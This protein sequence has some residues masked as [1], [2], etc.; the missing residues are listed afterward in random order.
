ME[1]EKIVC[2]TINFNKGQVSVVDPGCDYENIVKLVPGEY[3]CIGIFYKSDTRMG[4]QPLIESMIVRNDP[5]VIER[6]MKPFQWEPLGTV[7]VDCGV[8]GYFDEKPAF[9]E[10]A[11]KAFVKRT[12]ANSDE[13]MFVDSDKYRGFWTTTGGDGSYEVEGITNEDGVCEAVSICFCT[14]W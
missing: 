7:D 13:Y 5:D 3:I 1:P 12:N 6:T 9:T 11:W 8:A 14:G 2:G 4:N 10:E